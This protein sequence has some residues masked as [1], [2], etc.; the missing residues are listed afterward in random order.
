VNTDYESPERDPLWFR[1]RNISVK[2]C[3]LFITLTV[4]LEVAILT[5][6]GYL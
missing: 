1:L 6:L 5:I 2:Q 4:A 3:L